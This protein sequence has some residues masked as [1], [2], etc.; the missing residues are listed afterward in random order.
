MPNVIAVFQERSELMRDA[1]FYPSVYIGAPWWF[2][3]APD[4]ILR[5]RSASAAAPSVMVHNLRR[6]I[7]LFPVEAVNFEVLDLRIAQVRRHEPGARSAGRGQLAQDR[8]APA[9]G[10]CQRLVIACQRAD[11][12]VS[13]LPLTMAAATITT[14]R[15]QPWPSSSRPRG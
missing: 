9:G 14:D 8:Q 13:A 11:G 6:S 5:W 15:R 3:D 2:L 12:G 7:C 4:A 10:S 1:G